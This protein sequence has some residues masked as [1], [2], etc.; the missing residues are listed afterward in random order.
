MAPPTPIETLYDI[1]RH[2]D[3][4]FNGK[5]ISVILKVS[6]SVVSK[7]RNGEYGLLPKFPHNVEL[8]LKLHNLCLKKMYEKPNINRKTDI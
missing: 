4:G 1:K 2:L 3:N 6:E 5:Q 7:V 8:K